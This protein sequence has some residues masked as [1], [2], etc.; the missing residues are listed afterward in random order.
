MLSVRRCCHPVLRYAIFR[1]MATL[2]LR[3]ALTMLRYAGISAF[4]ASEARVQEPANHV[5]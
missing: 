2:L 4:T 3:Y 1:H 5:I